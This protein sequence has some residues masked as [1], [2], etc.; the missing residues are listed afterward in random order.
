MN[1]FYLT[2]LSGVLYKVRGELLLCSKNL[3]T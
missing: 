2:D 3:A 1:S